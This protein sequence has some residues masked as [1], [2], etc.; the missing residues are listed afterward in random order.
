MY[1]RERLREVSNNL[2]VLISEDRLLFCSF[3]KNNI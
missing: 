3:G 2:G 1:R